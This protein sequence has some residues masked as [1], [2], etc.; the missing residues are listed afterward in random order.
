MKVHALFFAALR[1]HARVGEREIEVLRP[2][3]VRELFIGQ[4]PDQGLAQ[5]LLPSVRFAVNCEYVSAE[6]VVNNGDEV[7]FIPPV[8]GG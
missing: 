3:T 2:M 5:R 8:S 7:A 1:D 6:T 4:F